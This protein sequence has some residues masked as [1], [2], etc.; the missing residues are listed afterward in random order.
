MHPS[1]FFLHCPR[2]ARPRTS[3]TTSPGQPFDCP[4]CGFRY[5]FNP[6]VAVAVFI[7]R[8]DGRTLLIRRGKDPA[9]GRLAPAG[10]FIDIG[11]RAE[12][13]VGREIAEELG[14]RLEQV[15]FLCSQPNQYRF[16]E[17]TYP[18]L[19]LFFTATTTDRTL[20][21]DPEEVG[22][23]DWYDPV[24]VAAE[25]LAFPSMQAAW[26]RMMGQDAAR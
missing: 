10:G 22:A 9:K 11:E 6:A 7:R 19:D 23:A 8:E 14:I 2:C 20:R 1:E 13:A 25:D 26:R 5:Y 3:T 4:G 18:V 15:G 24:E 16:R 17:V 12:D 21:I